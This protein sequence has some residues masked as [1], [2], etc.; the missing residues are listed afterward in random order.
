M[1]NFTVVAL[2]VWPYG[3]PNHHLY[4]YT[5][6]YDSYAIFGAVSQHFKAITMKCGVTLRTWDSLPTPNFFKIA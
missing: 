5:K 1:P 2:K 4:I 6:N 3:P